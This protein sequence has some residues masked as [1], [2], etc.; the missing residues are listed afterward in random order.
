M[1]RVY[2][3][4]GLYTLNLH[5]ERAV[6]CKPALQALLATSQE[7]PLPVW[8]SSLKDIAAWWKER[9]QFRWRITS[10]SADRWL[11]EAECTSR[12]TVVARNV[13]I[14]DCTT[15][16]WFKGNVRVEA[17]TFTVQSTHC[18]CIGVSPQCPQEIDD[19]LCSGL[20]R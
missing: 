5:P 11:I 4:G 20:C 17:Q 14:E 7:Q 13:A 9:S 12:A 1:R 8:V 6:L 10:Q 2:D 15:T 19:F 3:L 18:P 16:P